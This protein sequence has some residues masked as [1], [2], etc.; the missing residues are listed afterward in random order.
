MNTL[1]FRDCKTDEQKAE[2]KKLV[3][4]AA[5]T[6]KVLKDIVQKLLDEA[7]ANELKKS[8][9]ESPSWPYMQADLLGTKR[10]YSQILTL[11]D[12]EEK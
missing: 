10:A 3:G 4:S 12:Q 5:P 7:D 8:N 6:L 9:Y 1:W 2:R 11:L